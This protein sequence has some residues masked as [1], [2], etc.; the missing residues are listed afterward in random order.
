M[1]RTKERIN[2][3][4]KNAIDQTATFR[5]QMIELKKEFINKFAK[6][7]EGD[8][9]FVSENKRIGLRSF[10]TVKT[11]AFVEKVICVDSKATSEGLGIEYKLLKAKKDGSPSKHSFGYWMYKE[12][13][14]SKYE[15]D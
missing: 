4:Y 11:E 9:V 10:E 15:E 8:K 1:E 5:M 6:F 13:Q 3:E 7:K 12:E 14:L 2:L